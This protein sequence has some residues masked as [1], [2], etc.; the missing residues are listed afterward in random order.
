VSIGSIA[1]LTPLFQT[2]IIKFIKTSPILVHPPFLSV[3][4]PTT[5]LTYL[6]FD[7]EICPLDRFRTHYLL[8]RSVSDLFAKVQYHHPVNDSK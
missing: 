3:V 5:G 2:A 1:K 7:P 6:H 4:S 8:R